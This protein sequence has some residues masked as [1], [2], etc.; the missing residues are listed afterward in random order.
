MAV[1]LASLLALWAVVAALGALKTSRGDLATAA[2]RGLVGAV[3]CAFI[4]AGVL[5]VALVGNDFSIRFVADNSSWHMPQRFILVA[6]LNDAGGALLVWA[7]LAGAAALVAAR[8]AAPAPRAWITIVTGAALAVGLSI[9]AMVADPFAATVAA[10]AD[11]VA[12]APALQNG[13]AATHAIA[14]LVAAAAVLPAYA[15]T[16]A[17][18]A[19]RS[20]DDRWSLQM[21]WWNAVVWCALVVALVAGARWT[22]VTPLRGPWLADRATIL[23]IVPAVI[24]AWLIHLDAGR[25]TAGRVVQRV[26]LSTILF[27]ALTGTIAL[28]SGAFV[29]GFDPHTTR[30]DGTP[31]DP[32]AWFAAVAVGAIVLA[33][34]MFRATRGAIVAHRVSDAHAPHMVGAWFAHAGFILV[35]GAVIGGA[36]TRSHDIAL[37]DAAVFEVRDPFGHE[38]A[39]ASQG[40]STLRRENYASLTVSLLPTRDGDRLTMLS[41]EARSYISDDPRASPREG[42][43]A[44][45]VSNAFM[46][47]RLAITD[48]DAS[49]QAVRVSFVPLAPWLVPGALLIVLGTLVPLVADRK[50]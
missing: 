2:Q 10:V 15:L 20:L 29:Q 38:W 16:V 27:V 42:F 21:R 50:A 46:E 5:V 12:I 8:T 35:A 40:V 33:A 13:S 14:L 23:W 1:A 19:T 45:A 32:G 36:F 9:V 25:A 43:T 48:P 49:P 34:F 24:G 4:A 18:V 17:A 44:G 39:F 37:A 11:G 30:T 26:V 41:A 7:A 22:A 6:L 31:G 3:A 28:L 47:T